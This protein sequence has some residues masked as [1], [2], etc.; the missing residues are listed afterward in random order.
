[1]AQCLCQCGCVNT[2][3]EQMNWRCKRCF[4]NAFD[5]SSPCNHN[6]CVGCHP[7]IRLNESVS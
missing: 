5:E 4:T 1:M 2:R 7:E 3:E 6:N